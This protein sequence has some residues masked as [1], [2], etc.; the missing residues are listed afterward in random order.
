MNYKNYYDILGVDEDASQEEI[1][2]AYRKLAREYHPDF[3]PD[4]EESEEKFK[5]M[6][7]AYE[8]LSDPEKRKRYDSL[9]A[10]WEKYAK[11]GGGGGFGGGAGGRR[12]GGPQEGFRVH[13]EDASGMSGFSDFFEQIFGDFYSGGTGQ[14]MNI[15]EVFGEGGQGR[16]GQRSRGQTRRRRK[17][18]GEDVENIIELT[19][20]E[21][22]HGTERRLRLQ[23]P[24]VC[25]ECGRSPSPSCQKCQGRGV[26][27][28]QKTVTVQVPAGVNEGSKIRLKGEGGIGRGG[29]QRGHL[30][31][32]VHLKEHP[33]FDLNDNDL[34][35]EVPISPHEA[36]EGGEIEV[37]GIDDSVTMN[38]PP[39]TEGGQQFRLQGMGMPELNNDG[40]GDQ[41]VTVQIQIPSDLSEE[42]QEALSTFQDYNPRKEEGYL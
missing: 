8:V 42:Q 27:T 22:F 29:G 11:S 1:K 34:Y 25:P 17:Q 39:G 38:L 30:F 36:A 40:R 32:K 18:R 21:A 41:Y 4:D 13:W 31:L 3:N 15:E 14:R 26:V 19:L 16:P 7:E 12:A 37:P 2:R 35:C 9:G 10:D 20:E 6:K 24:E 23:Q 28:N 33:I 5:E